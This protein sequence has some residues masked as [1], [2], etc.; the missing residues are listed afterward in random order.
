[1]RQTSARPVAAAFS[2]IHKTDRRSRT[3]TGALHDASPGRPNYQPTARKT[4]THSLE[5]DNVRSPIAPANVSGCQQK[6]KSPPKEQAPHVE[7]IPRSEV[8]EVVPLVMGMYIAGHGR[9]RDGET[10]LKLT[11]QSNSIDEPPFLAWVPEHSL[12]YLDSDAVYEYWEDLPG[13]RDYQLGYVAKWNAN[14]AAGRDKQEGIRWEIFRISECRVRNR[15]MELLVHWQGYREQE[16]SW[17]P[18]RDLKRQAPKTVA[19][20]WEQQNDPTAVVSKQWTQS[21]LS[22]T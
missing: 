14:I 13:G 6:P 1:M 4:R 10:V 2:S 22:I 20:F 7:I 15:E 9:M 5:N 3:L 12:Q 18:E 8:A 16:S 21:S 17:I 11:R 19:F